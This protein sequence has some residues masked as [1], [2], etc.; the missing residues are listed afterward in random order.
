MALE[1]HIRRVI[2][3]DDPYGQ[4]APGLV[5]GAIELRRFSEG[6]QS[7]LI[8][9]LFYAPIVL[10][11]PRWESIPWAWLAAECNQMYMATYRGLQAPSS[12][13]EVIR[14]T[15]CPTCKVAPGE[16]CSTVRSRDYVRVPVTTHKSR[17][18]Q[19]VMR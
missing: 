3:L 15:A 8:V 2:N 17:L 7:V 13:E 18:L 14:M 12:E 4:I 6:S 9:T 5:C 19:D 16:R 10:D 11:R 1:F